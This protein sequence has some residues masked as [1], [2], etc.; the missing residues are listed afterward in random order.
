MNNE[1]WNI[2][3]ELEKSKLAD[4]KC[5]MMHIAY[6]AQRHKDAM[7]NIQAAVGGP[8]IIFGLFPLERKSISHRISQEGADKLAELLGSKP[9]WWEIAQLHGC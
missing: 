8:V 6:V 2:T 5:L 4:R 7:P 1:P 9:M 3:I